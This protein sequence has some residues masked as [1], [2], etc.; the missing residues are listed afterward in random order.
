MKK[1]VNLGES[2]EKERNLVCFPWYLILQGE[3]PWH[4]FLF[5]KNSNLFS[6]GN[7]IQRNFK[8]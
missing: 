6:I 4:I 3:I 8:D 5:Y 1:H 7:I 2:I